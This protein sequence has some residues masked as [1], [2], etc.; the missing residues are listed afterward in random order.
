MVA[1]RGEGSGKSTLIY[2]SAYRVDVFYFISISA[3]PMDFLPRAIRIYIEI[4]IFT[5]IL[6]LFC[7]V[8]KDG[9]LYLQCLSNLSR[10][11]LYLYNATR[12]DIT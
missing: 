4:L 6:P 3:M 12:L 8:I 2:S 5:P 11:I 9:V 10:Y 7:F 1:S